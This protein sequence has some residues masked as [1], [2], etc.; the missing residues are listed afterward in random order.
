MAA[1]IIKA[2]WCLASVRSDQQRG[3]CHGV[4][5]ETFLRQE[6]QKAAVRKHKLAHCSDCLGSCMV[7][8]KKGSHTE[9]LI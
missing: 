3:L 4:P 9:T 6:F 1:L 7:S 5:L 2:S 8:C